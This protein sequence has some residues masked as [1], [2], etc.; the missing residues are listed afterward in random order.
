[1]IELR[2]GKTPWNKGL[3]TGLVPKSAF[4]KGY[5]Q[6]P[7]LI[8]KR[9]QSRKG[10]KHSQETK[11]KIG[12]G[13]KGKQSWSKGLTG[14]V[15]AKHKFSPRPNGS[16]EK[17]YKWLGGYSMSQHK[18]TEY[19]TWRTSV[20][21]RDDFKCKIGNEDCDGKI[22]AH[23]ILSFTKY[24][25]LRYEINNGITLCRKHHPRK[26]AEEVRLAPVFQDIVLA[27]AN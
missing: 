20:Y 1:M 15:R 4:K 23:H 7:E 26:M 13:N 10:Y 3:K 8:A 27:I 17:H 11:A 22:E 25:E 21:K 6:S 19:N 2:K 14:I 9:I 12:V 18:G 5:K 24:P 16:G